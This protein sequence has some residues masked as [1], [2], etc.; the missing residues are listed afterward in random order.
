[1]F[2]HGV[3]FVK[4]VSISKTAWAMRTGVSSAVGENKK[5]YDLTPHKPSWHKND[6]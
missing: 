4:A 2:P 5:N 3:H 1:M 6:K